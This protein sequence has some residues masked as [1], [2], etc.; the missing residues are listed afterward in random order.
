MLL[1][2]ITVEVSEIFQEN[3][4]SGVYLKLEVC[5]ARNI[6]SNYSSEGTRDNSFSMCTKFSAN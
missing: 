2:I 4:Y 3:T 5:E 1:K 6:F